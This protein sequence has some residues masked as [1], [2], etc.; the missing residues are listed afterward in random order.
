MPS[1]PL[2][3]AAVTRAISRQVP[4]AVESIESVVW[5]RVPISVCSAARSPSI[6]FS[7]SQ[8]RNR[9]T[10]LCT[11]AAAPRLAIQVHNST[12]PHLAARTCNSTLAP[13]WTLIYYMHMASRPS[14]QGDVTV[15][16]RRPV[17]ESH[18]P[19]A[20]SV[21]LRAFQAQL[22]FAAAPYST[23]LVKSAYQTTSLDG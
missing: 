1:S 22:R 4:W 11:S 3:L 6:I 19:T 5:N 12:K 20:V 23:S 13:Q 7:E 15:A 14:V 2:R 17:T 8:P 9:R 18:S 21:T 10:R 16:S